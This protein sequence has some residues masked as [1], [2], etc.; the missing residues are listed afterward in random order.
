MVIKDLSQEKVRILEA[1][2]EC[3]NDGAI[4]E[5]WGGGCIMTRGVIV[6]EFSRKRPD[7]IS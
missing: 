5:K 4:Y 1:E 7:C 3:S 6:N 2:W